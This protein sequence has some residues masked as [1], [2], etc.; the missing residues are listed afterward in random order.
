MD[1]YFA[2]GATGFFTKFFLFLFG[3][4]EYVVNF[5]EKL[6]LLITKSQE[7]INK[8][9]VTIF[10][11]VAI[12]VIAL[13]FLYQG[14]GL[15][16]VELNTRLYSLQEYAVGSETGQLKYDSPV[17]EALAHKISIAVFLMALVTI[18]QVI[19]EIMSRYIHY[20]RI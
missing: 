8:A 4:F 17:V 12:V 3:V 10:V 19:I 13:A 6:P 1:R 16:Q 14:E 18:Y 7:A 9:R 5:T 20:L 15:S 11:V 2:S